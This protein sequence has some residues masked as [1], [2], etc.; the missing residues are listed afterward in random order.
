V[1][2]CDVGVHTFFKA[3]QGVKQNAIYSEIIL[4]IVAYPFDDENFIQIL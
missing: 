2:V 3:E 4:H 1:V